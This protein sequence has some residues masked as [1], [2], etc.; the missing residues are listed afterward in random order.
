M[1][2]NGQIYHAE[3]QNK[4]PNPRPN[5]T[6]TAGAPGVV[7]DLEGVIFQLDRRNLFARFVV[8]PVLWLSHALSRHRQ[9]VGWE[10]P[11]HVGVQV[12]I[13]L[14]SGDLRRF[15]VEQIPTPWARTDRG[16]LRWTPLD[17]FRTRSGDGWDFLVPSDDFAGIGT[18]QV[19]MA[20]ARL[21]GLRGRPY[22]AELCT[23]M[24]ERVFGGRPMFKRV[25]LLSLLSPRLRIPDPTAPLVHP[26]NLRMAYPIR[27]TPTARSAA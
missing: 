17:E 21:N 10:L 2:S 1:T 5:E 25:E 16:G 27:R 26:A 24:V 6:L 11:N 13:R 4:L 12:Q 9:L 14:P 20:L 15:V 7:V 8:R 18:D 19:Q 22:H 3:S 23:Q